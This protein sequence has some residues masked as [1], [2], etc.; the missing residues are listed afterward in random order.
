MGVR[1]RRETC[2]VIIQIST[3]SLEPNSFSTVAKGM[4]WSVAGIGLPYGKTKVFKGH[5][6]MWSHNAVSLLRAPRARPKRQMDS[7][8]VAGEWLKQ[9]MDCRNV[10]PA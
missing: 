3:S 10:R 6:S 7:R 8:R 5:A 9:Q 1:L 4:H 2:V